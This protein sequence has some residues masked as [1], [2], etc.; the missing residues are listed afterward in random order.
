VVKK[1]ITSA[2]P[3]A[4]RSTPTVA[5]NPSG[6]PTSETRASS[7]IPSFFGRGVDE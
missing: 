3:R 1:T 2:S 6:A 7:V 5:L 4:L